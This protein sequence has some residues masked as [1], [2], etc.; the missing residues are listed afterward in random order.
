MWGEVS[1]DFHVRMISERYKRESIARE[2]PIAHFVKGVSGRYLINVVGGQLPMAPV[3]RY[4]SRFS[5]TG[6][7]VPMKENEI[8]IVAGPSNWEQIGNRLG[9]NYRRSGVKWVEQYVRKSLRS[10][11]GPIQS[12]AHNPKVVSSNLTPRNQ[13]MSF[14]RLPEKRGTHR[15]TQ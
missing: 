1:W 9:T 14:A 4:Q 7:I 11:D 13:L 15:D 12:W 2:R 6:I 10:K 8:L 5:R 3:L